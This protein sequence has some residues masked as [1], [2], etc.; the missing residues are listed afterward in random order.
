MP[1]TPTITPAP[2]NAN[3]NI[4][5]TSNANDIKA[6]QKLNNLAE[7]GTFDTNTKTAYDYLKSRNMVSSSSSST[8]TS[9]VIATS[10]QSR[11]NYN[12]NVSTIQGAN[13]N[14]KTVQ[15]GQ[16]ASGIAASL[17]QTPEQ[18]LKNNPNFA[19]TGG[20]NDYK[21]LSGN[22]QI[23]QTYKVGPDGSSNPVPETPPKVTTNADGT[24]STKNADGTM[25]NTN[26]DGTQTTTNPDGTKS[27]IDPALKKQFD[28]N[29]ASLE[30]SSNDA[31]ATMDSA[32]A[33]LNND[34]AAAAAADNIKKQFDVLIQQMKDKNAILLGS[35]KTSAARN[36]GYEYASKMTDTFIAGEVNK[37]T[38]RVA[39]LVQKENDA[40]MKSNMAYK[41][42]DVKALDAATKDYQK[43]LEDKQKAIL[44]LNKAINDAVKLGQADV[45]NALAEKNQTISNDVKIS[46]ALGKSIAD[47]IATSGIKDPAQIDEYIKS[48][49]E[50]NGISNPD[51]LKSAFIK[52]QQA[53]TSLDLKNKNTQSI[54][55][56]RGKTT[57][58]GDTSIPGGKGGGTDGGYKYSG[59]DITTYTTFLN[60]G[61]TTPE[62]NAYA[63]RGDDGFVD[64][65]TYIYAYK[66]WIKNNG[67]VAGFLKKFP[68]AKNVNPESVDS[69][70]AA[71][72][73]K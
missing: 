8:G 39:D 44:D 41:S 28:D 71:L 36:G 5:L 57:P 42:G 66:D 72:T 54:I 60:Q 12:N 24:T 37:G 70:P 40:I 55:N 3:Q 53:T 49:A 7:S 16:T 17:G 34:P 52:E 26:P 4:S 31:K 27:T 47:Q 61:G 13:N 45:K 65:G 2:T 50:K 63:G 62:G 32:L 22:I 46:T 25:I 1:T 23:G 59:D 56:N 19:A 51:I 68:V 64:P 58:T 29:M 15:A 18:F 73:N 38:Q 14:L 20:K 48:M 35:Y 6:F 21:G 9:S 30:Q 69:L 67:S 10:N 43:T 33:T 11:T